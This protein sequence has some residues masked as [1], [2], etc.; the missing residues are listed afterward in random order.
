M[1]VVCALVPAYKVAVARLADPSL[2][3]RPL[4]VADKRERGHAIA[5]DEAA[6][7]LGAR[8][9]MTLVQAGAAA[10][11]AAI[12]YD[13]P[14]RCRTLWERALDALDVASPLVEDAGD[15]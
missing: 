12:A 13:D 4:I 8:A 14:A 2:H 9:G 11:E 10:R 15:G 6:Y 5:L 7:A 3:D 1:P